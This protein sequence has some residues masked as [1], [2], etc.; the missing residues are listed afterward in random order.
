[1]RKKLTQEEKKVKVTV[2]INPVL[3]NKVDEFISNKSKY[4]E[5]LIY[6]DLKNKDMI[7]EMML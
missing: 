6:K 7:K 5:W 2:T 4:I 1:M 3:M